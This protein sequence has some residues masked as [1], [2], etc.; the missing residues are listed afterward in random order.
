MNKKPLDELQNLL[1]DKD[2]EVR[3]RDEFPILKDAW[4]NYQRLLKYYKMQIEKKR[5]Q[6]EEN[7]NG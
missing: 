5:Y 1:K 3:L 6:N 2:Q 4:E 7:I